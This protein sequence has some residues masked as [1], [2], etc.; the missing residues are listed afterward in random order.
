MEP[1]FAYIDP[2]S[3]SW[4]AHGR[5]GSYPGQEVVVFDA[6]HGCFLLCAGTDSDISLDFSFAL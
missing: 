4:R 2:G 5:V 6:E 3:G 1:L